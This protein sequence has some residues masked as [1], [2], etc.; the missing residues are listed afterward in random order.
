MVGTGAWSAVP[1]ATKFWFGSSFL[2][3]F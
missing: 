1:Y 3:Y 2:I